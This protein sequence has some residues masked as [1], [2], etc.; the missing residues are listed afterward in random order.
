MSTTS[1]PSE[2]N[3]NPPTFRFSTEELP[4]RERLTAWREIFG[5][6]VCSLD[7]DPLSPKGLRSEATICRL[8][9]LGAMMGSTSSVRL[10]HSKELIRDDDLSFA[11]FPLSSWTAS[12]MGRSPVLGAGDGVLMS[13]AEVGS[14]TLPMATRFVTF[15][16]PLAAI[17]PLVPD[18]GAAVARPVPADSEALRLLTRYFGILQENSALTTPHLRHLAA[19]HV[20]DLLALAVGATSDAAEVAGGRGLRA[21]RLEAILAEIKAH[22]ADPGFSAGGV[23][24]TLGLSPRYVQD[25]LHDT[26][27][28]FTERVLEL[29]LRKARAMLADAGRRKMQIIDIAYACGFGDVSYF[30]RCVRRRFGVAPS[31]ARGDDGIAG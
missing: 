17:A 2:S 25:L 4:A 31:A 19:T 30:N 3:G 21:A 8:P 26:G 22:F 27:V 16:V 24:K 5:R 1:L 11:T 9:G 7:I 28:S 15:R 18:I 13:N 14:M 6:T 23:A 29:K 20:H 12:Q 10:T